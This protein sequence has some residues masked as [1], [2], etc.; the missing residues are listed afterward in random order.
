MPLLLDI[1]HNSSNDCIRITKEF[2]DYFEDKIIKSIPKKTLNARKVFVSSRKI[3][4][5]WILNTR[6]I[7]QGYAMI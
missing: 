6:K 3:V 4:L 1:K 7:T 2:E 5:R